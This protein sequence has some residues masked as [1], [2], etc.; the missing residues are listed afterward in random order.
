V[1]R[2]EEVV[3]TA[4]QEARPP[5]I[6]WSEVRRAEHGVDSFVRRDGFIQ[7]QTVPYITPNP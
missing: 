1:P 4:P 7:A 3:G 5:R 2:D 6:P